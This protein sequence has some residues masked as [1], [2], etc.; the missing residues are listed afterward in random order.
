MEDQL[1]ELGWK[2]KSRGLLKGKVTFFRA[3]F[4]VENRSLVDL[5]PLTENV[6]KARIHILSTGCKISAWHQFTSSLLIFFLLSF[7]A[8]ARNRLS[9][10]FLSKKNSASSVREFPF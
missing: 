5:L 10:V 7:A 2:I 3:V 6:G 4:H 1:R 8:D 9:C